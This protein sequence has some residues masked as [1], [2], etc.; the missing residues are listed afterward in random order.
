MD[1]G[2]ANENN[3]EEIEEDKYCIEKILEVVQEDIIDDIL[4]VVKSIYNLETKENININ[5]KISLD[6]DRDQDQIQ[7]HLNH[8]IDQVQKEKAP[9]KERKNIN[10]K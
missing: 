9:Q 7:N 10:N 4:L 1:I 2:K 3:K 5:I 8:Q 6:R